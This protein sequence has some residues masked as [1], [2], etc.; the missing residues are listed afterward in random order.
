ME[1][2]GLAIVLIVVVAVATAG[3]CRWRGVPPAL[4]LLVVGLA[5]SFLPGLVGQ[6]PDPE[7]VLVLLLAPLVFALALETSYLDLR[8]ASRP[9]LLLAVGLVV[10]TTLTIGVV[11]SAAEPSIPFAVACA[12]GAILAPTDAV[13][14]SSSGRAAGLPRRVLTIIEGESL[15]NDGTALTLLRVAIIAVAAGSVSTA[16]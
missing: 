9:I 15:V 1:T 14:A 2:A 10:V 6:V 7:Q 12:L 8:A 16:S 11:A 4:P 5:L 3:L 13:A